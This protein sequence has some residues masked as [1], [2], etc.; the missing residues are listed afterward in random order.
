MSSGVFIVNFEHFSLIASV[1]DIE[2]TNYSWVDVFLV[3]LMFT[4]NTFSKIF[5]WR[6]GN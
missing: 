2:Q 1:A 4:L 6:R 3:P 5:Q